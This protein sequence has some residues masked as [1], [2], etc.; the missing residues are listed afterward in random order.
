[1]NITN[2]ERTEDKFIYTLDNGEVNEF[3]LKDEFN[4]YTNLSD[5]EVLLAR[6][7]PVVEITIN[8]V[9]V[10]RREVDSR[11]Q[12]YKDSLDENGVA[13]DQA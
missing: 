7:L 13:K 2:I 6:T 12:E 1:M 4:D 8:G 5:E 3:N 9:A 10:E 11:S